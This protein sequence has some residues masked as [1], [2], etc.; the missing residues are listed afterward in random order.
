[1]FLS[2]RI[3]FL[4]LLA[5]FVISLPASAQPV[6]PA[7]CTPHFEA[8]QGWQGADAAYSIP[9]PDGRDV[10]I[11]GDTLYGD[12][13]VV[14]GADPRMVRNTLGISSCANGEWK[15][16]YVIRHNADGKKLDFFPS[17]DPKHWYW[18]LDGVYYNKELWVTLLCVRNTDKSVFELGFEVCGTD[19]A[20]VSGLDRDPQQ[21]KVSIT[22]LVPDGIRS[23]PS[24][25]TVISGKYLYIY[26]LVEFG[27][28]PQALTRIALGKLS[29]AKRNL[30]YLSTDGNWKNGFDPKTSKIV[31]E[32]GASEM[33][34]RYHPD[35]KKWVAVMVDPTFFSDSVFFR[36]AD[37]ME[38]PWTRAEVI[39]R[40][41]EMDKN[42]AGFDKDT[43]CYAGKEHPEFE[44]PGELVFTYTCNTMKPE[45]L[46]TE[47]NIYFPQVVRMKMP[48]KG[49]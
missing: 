27:S 3:S 28:R 47:P 43:Y 32:P 29:D 39:Y 33:S 25:S 6:S 20:R 26:S 46:L 21:W 9:L 48:T 38:G 17:A 15:L 18:A 2:S 36:T 23:Y 31:M 4:L 37:Q 12:K 22:N 7:G 8:A 40:I 11:F 14:V 30:E 49:K 45:K 10:W 44:M 41:P 1:M 16:D 42:R 5:L 13:R 24:A 19:L 34:V 35:M